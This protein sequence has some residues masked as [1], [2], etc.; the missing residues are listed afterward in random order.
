MLLI[1]LGILLIGFIYAGLLPYMVKRTIAHVRFDLVRQTLSFLSNRDLY[2]QKYVKGYKR[3]LF[4]TA[5]LTYI[6]FWLLSEFYDLGD[7]EV[8]MQQIDISFAILT[9]L[10]FVPHN[11]NPYSLGNLKASVLR[12]LHNILAVMLFLMLPALIIMFQFSV[13]PQM[14]FLGISGLIGI[15][16]VMV[17]TIVSVLMNGIN[18]VTEILFIEGISLWSLYITILT[19]LR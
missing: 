1:K 14:Y 13:L 7:N 3:L 11:I 6:Y 2:G 16:A 19:L 4:A 5:C 18:G 17:V 8:L 9:L 10:A 12:I 15:G